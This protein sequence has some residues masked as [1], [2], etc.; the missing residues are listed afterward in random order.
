MGLRVA[1]AKYKKVRENL[2]RQIQQGHFPPGAQL[3]SE[4]QLIKS[5]GVSKIT[6]VRA[7]NDLARDGLIVRQHGRG[8]FVVDP[9]DQ[10]LA[11]GRSLRFALLIDHSIGA[12][13]QFMR[14]CERELVAAILKEWGMTSIEPQFHRIETGTWAEWSAGLKGCTFQVIGEPFSVRSRRPSIAQVREAR[15]DGIMTLSI[16]DE[17]WLRELADLHLPHVFLDHSSQAGEAAGDAVYF[18]PMPGYRA[19]VRSFAARGA[20]RIHF[21]GG[22]LHRPY[23]SMTELQSDPDYHRLE[24]ALPD[25]ES[26]LRKAAWR[27][28]MEACGLPWD[29]SCEHHTWNYPESPHLQRFARDLAALPDDRRPQALVCHGLPQ[30]EFIASAFKQAGLPL[31]AAGA[32]PT[33]QYNHAW[34]IFASYERMGQIGAELLLRRLIHPVGGSLHVG[35]PMLLPECLA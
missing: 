31:L 10:P 3:P 4:G 2:R 9:A 25:P 7:L 27:I 14:E 12:N 21:V 8:S 29:A 1:Q 34:P 28:E 16:V 18:D 15:L 13:Y 24:N 30:A 35:I 23:A 17:E 11:P 33:A 22:L 32:T 5:L 20:K 19:A 26:I 6:L